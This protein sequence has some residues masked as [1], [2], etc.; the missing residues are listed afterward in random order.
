MQTAKKQG[1]YDRS[2]L[3]AEYTR[4]I[5]LCEDVGLRVDPRDCCKYEGRT[6]LLTPVFTSPKSDYEFCLTIIDDKPVFAGDK[7]F[8]GEELIEIRAINGSLFHSVCKHEVSHHG[9]ISSLSW[10][11]KLPVFIKPQQRY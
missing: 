5:R 10:A 11:K 2:E 7:L 6:V 8:F 4:V 9:N 1:K 3:F